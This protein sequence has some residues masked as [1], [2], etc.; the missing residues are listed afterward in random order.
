MSYIDLPCLYLAS[1]H[2]SVFLNVW[3]TVIIIISVSLLANSNICIISGSILIELL[4]IFLIVGSI[5]LLLLP[6]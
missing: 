4:I 5:F 2:S 3:N 1:C 6:A